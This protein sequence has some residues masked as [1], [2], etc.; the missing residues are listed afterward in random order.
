[1]SV[2]VRSRAAMALVALVTGVLAAGCA[3]NDDGESTTQPADAGPTGPE[4]LPPLASVVLT[5]E[6][7]IVPVHALV[8]PADEREPSSP[9]S[10]AAMLAEGYGETSLGAGQPHVTRTLD[11]SPA[12]APGPSPRRLVRFVHLSDLHLV[13]DESPVRLANLDS[14]SATAGA[15]RSQDAYQCRIVNAMVRTINAV[16]AT[17]PLDFVLLGGDGVDSAQQNELG[18]LL[19]LL[20]GPGELDC[21]SGADDDPLPEAD[22]PKDP[23]APS[24]LDVPWYWTTGNHDILRQGSFVVDDEQIAD[25]LGTH[26]SGGTRDWSQPGGPLFEGP[27]VADPARRL[28]RP[29][30]LLAMVAD[31]GDA[32]GFGEA[33]V[34]AG[35]AFYA[36]DIADSPLRFVVLDTAAQ[37]GAAEGVLR[38]AELDSFLVPALE[39][40]EADG[41]W[42]VIVSHHALG[43]LGDGSGFGGSAQPDA[44]PAD[45]LLDVLGGYA[46]V[47]FAFAGHAHV[48]HV[49]PQQPSGGHG[50]WELMTGAL[51]DWPHQARVVEIWDEGAGSVMLRA[52]CV[53]YATDGDPLAAEGRSYGVADFVSGWASDGRGSADDRN[54][55]LWIA[56]P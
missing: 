29:T 39:Q 2:E 46:N 22:D 16:H 6:Q 5:D 25:S 7:T 38:R 3:G 26:A 20:A 13:D 41:R 34:A 15:F 32:H 18:W 21:D 53:D 9:A 27:V 47:L 19:G 36:F 4:P 54:V 11:G 23:F 40:A 12:P 48:H 55:E 10:L 37:T 51:A 45:E 24:G 14:T 30:E 42:V 43:S 28:L 44:V 50:F 52:T 49:S 17:D 8:S 35:R 56:A 31:A 1:M 33:E